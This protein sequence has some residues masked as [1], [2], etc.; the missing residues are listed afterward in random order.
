MQ[1]RLLNTDSARTKR[2]ETHSR[3]E[4]P[5]QVAIPTTTT[6]TIAALPSQPPRHVQSLRSHPNHH[7][8]YNRCVPIPT[9][10]TRT[11]AAFPSQPPRHVQSLRSHL[12]HHD[13]HSRRD[14]AAGLAVE[15]A[16]KRSKQQYPCNHM[17]GARTWRGGDARSKVR[18]HTPIGT[19]PRPIFE[20]KRVMAQSVLWWGTTWEY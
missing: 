1:A 11:I 16:R 12:N 14:P 13:T 20:V 3:P 15:R 4:H 2:R 9:T 19:E 17:T 10:T 7:D 6:R 8:T 5:E 18:P